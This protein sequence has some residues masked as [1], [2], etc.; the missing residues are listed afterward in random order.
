MNMAKRLEQAFAGVATVGERG[1]VVIP[2]NA[3]EELRI[4][5]G[6]KLLVFLTP[7]RHMVTM[8]KF[9]SLEAVAHEL[10][11][12]LHTLADHTGRE[13]GADDDQDE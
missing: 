12:L 11:Q 1:Q 2:A 3:R 9:S 8:A 5:A 6:D 10:E 4:N 13:V 7:D